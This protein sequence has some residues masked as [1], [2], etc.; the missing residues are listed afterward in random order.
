MMPS[1]VVPSC[2]STAAHSA[3]TSASLAQRD[4]TGWPSPSEWVFES[5]V[6]N[7]SPPAVIAVSSSATMAATSASVASRPTASAPIT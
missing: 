6:E 4:A 1:R 7:P 2:R 5:V 3:S